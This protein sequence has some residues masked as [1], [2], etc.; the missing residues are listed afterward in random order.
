MENRPVA[1][2]TGCSTGIGFEASLDLARKGYLVFATMRNL[3]KAGVLKKAAKGLPVVILALDVD[4]PLAAQKVVSAIVRKTERIDV[5]INNA[6]F[7]A[8]GMLEEFTDEEIKAQYETNVFGLMRMTNAVLPVMR[9][10]KNGR[11]LHIGSLAGRM[12]FAGIG[13]YCSSKHA[14]EAL[15]EA[16]RPE[17]RPFNIEVAVIEPG[18]TNTPFKYNRHP[19]QKFR[20]GRSDYQKVLKKIL[21]YGN[22]QSQKAPGAE[23]V[24]AAILKALGSRRMA[25]RYAAGFDALWFPQVRWFLPDGVYDW[26]LKRMYRRFTTC[27]DLPRKQIMEIGTI[28]TSLKALGKVGMTPETKKQVALITGASSG[29]GLETAKLLAGKGYRVYATYRN[30]KK[31]KDLKVLAAKADVHPVLMETTKTSSVEKTLK[32]IVKQERRV[33]VLVNN[34]GFAMGGFLEDLSDQD[35]KDQFDTNVFGY[36]RVI[37]AVAPVMRKRQ[38]GKI[39]NVGS[40]AGRVAFPALG[41][42]A[43][44]K[45][46]VR[47]LS[48]ALRTELRPFGIEVAEVAPGSYI[49]QVTTSARYGKNVRSK[50]SPYREY[51]RQIEELMGREFSKGGPASDVAVLIGKALDQSPMK[52][53]YL[54]G[55]DAKFMAF[56]KWFLAD[57]VFEALLKRMIPWSRFPQ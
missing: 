13:L 30:P 16:M 15:T 23:Q 45:F 27:A 41:A 18:S 35:L 54:A 57:F 34:A 32:M 6:G 55:S 47:S 56:F 36:L 14:V 31:L 20:Q 40:I 12:T 22:S 46:A 38:S 49:T 44:S 28:P 39:I 52:P 19:A 37:R 21:A 24:V 43:A 53:V 8:F 17:V 1:L 7:G 50:R 48:Q 5:L 10:Q 11:I 3:K 33:D 9:A 4:Q 51:T 29:F 26:I 42:Y 2:I 25:V